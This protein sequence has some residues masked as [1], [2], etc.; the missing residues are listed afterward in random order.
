MAVEDKIRQGLLK[1]VKS[2]GGEVEEKDIVL[3]TPKFT[4]QGDLS[5]AVA[6]KLARTLHKA[7]AAIADEIIAAFP[8]GE[9]KEIKK[10]EKAGPGFVNFFLSAE[11]VESIVAEIN[12]AGES[13]GQLDYGKHEKTL[14]EYVSANPTGALHLGHARGA[15]IGDSLYRILSKCGYDVTREYYVNDAGNQINVLAESLKAR[16]LEK[17]G[18]KEAKVPENGYHGPD[19]I[20][21]AEKLYEEGKDSYKDK[22]LSF[23]RARG[24]ELALENIKKDLA[25]FRVEFDVFSSEQKIRD[26]GKVEQVLGLLKPVCYENEGALFLNTTKDGDDKDRVIVK[27][28]GSY[29]YLLPD[30]AYHKYK[31]DRGYSW[32]IDLLG[33]DH[34]G[35][36]ARIKSS[37]KSLGYNPDKLDVD[38]VQM[39]R[40]FK[41]GQEYK[42]SKRTGNAISLKELIEECGVDSVRF[43]FVSRANS[44]HLDF[45]IDL[46]KTL[47]TVNPVYYCQYAHAR[48]CALLEMGK[49]SYK[50]DASGEGLKE[51]SELALMKKL[52]DFKKVILDSGLT[53]SPSKITIYVRELAACVN[54]FYTQCR[55]LDPANPSLTAAR[56]GLVQASQIVLKEGL[57]LVGV[58]AP[59]HM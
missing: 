53:L 16:Y 19:I 22:E 28:D 18:D 5:S 36:I 33:A 24:I 10:I 20:A 14:L 45:N 29:T 44:Q 34:H 41:D 48:L 21:F 7:P 52:S 11:Q 47:G 58:N 2:I 55:V 54:D 49:A 17:L 3:E 30:I 35:Y 6:L 56:L 57:N 51:P 1:A 23:F 50:I 8:L 38:L 13:Y 43:F 59:E 26:D 39:V 32:L 15:A 27:S 12:A 4:A 37:M 25:E 42:M 46:A 9:I 31:F 40:L